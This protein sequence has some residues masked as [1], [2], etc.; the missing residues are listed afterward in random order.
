MLWWTLQQLK[1]SGWEKRVAAAVRLRSAHENRSVPALINALGDDHA[2]VR[3]E[4]VHALAVLAH[5]ASAEPLANAMAGLSRHK[6]E[7]RAPQESAEY[8]AIAVALGALQGVAVPPLLRLL[9]SEDKEARRWAAH[10]LGLTRDPRAVTPLVK[11]LSDSRSGARKAA[12]QALGAIGD[13]RALDPLIQVLANRDPETRRAAAGALGALGSDR[14]VAPLCGIAEDPN[15]P[16]QLAVVEALAKIGGLRAAAGLR[17]IIDSGRKNVR[18]AATAALGSLRLAP[19]NAEERAAAAVL[20]GDFQAAAGEG[21]AAAGALV[22]VLSSKDARRRQQAAE[23]LGL[24]RSPRVV[25]TLQR[26]LN[27]YDAAVREAALQALI[28]TGPAAVPGL[29]GMLSHYNPAMQCL[30]ARALGEIGDPRC[31][32]ALAALIDGNPVVTNEYKDI[33]DSMRAAAAALAAIL[34]KSPGEVAAGDLARIA[35]LPDPDLQSSS[36]AGLDYRELRALARQE[37]QRRE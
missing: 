2:A 21:E 31:V 30:A 17:A 20:M 8:E 27:D 28:R 24:L 10:A 4:V 25:E 14:A 6:K 5:P 1:S 15:E 35:G 11:H 16:V 19:A 29:I 33:L 32:A 7:A 12:A 34:A 3:L 36:E 9:D 37:L 22:A 18:E 13:L 26:A 23:A